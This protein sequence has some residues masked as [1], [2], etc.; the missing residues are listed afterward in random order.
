MSNKVV[1]TK[2]ITQR[3]LFVRGLRVLLDKD[4]AMLY[5]V[6]PIVLRQQVKRNKERFPLDFMF[7]LN[8]EEVNELV[9]QNVIPTKSS[10]G[11]HLPYVFTEQGV[12]MLSGVLKSQRAVIVNIAI[13]RAFVQLTGIFSKDKELAEKFKELESKL[14]KHDRQIM[15]IFKA[16]QALMSEPK[17]SK[18]KIGF[19]TT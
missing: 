19:H 2:V 7:Q 8:K 14:G 13:M 16:I 18:N 17:K 10:L 12:S 11:G 4:I 15:I 9:S 5:Q 1:S 3:I 6:K